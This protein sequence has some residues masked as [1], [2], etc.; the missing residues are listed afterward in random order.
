M[1]NDGAWWSYCLLTARMSFVALLTVAVAPFLDPDALAD[2]RARQVEISARLVEVSQSDI[3]ELGF[4]RDAIG[5]A[6]GRP[7]VVTRPTD[8]PPLP[9]DIVI[10]GLGSPRITALDGQQA[11]FDAVEEVPILAAGGV[12][13]VVLP[14]GLQLQIVPVIQ[15]DGSITMSIDSRVSMPS[16]EQGVPSLAT[17]TMDS[18][19]QMRSGQS[20][21]IGGLFTDSDRATAARV[22][23]LGDVPMIGQLFRSERFQ[24]GES[25]LLIFI[26]PV[27]IVGDEDAPM[28][29]ISVSVSGSGGYGEIDRGNFQLPIRV[30]TGG[31]FQDAPEFD[32][33]GT[34]FFSTRFGLNLDLGRLT[35]E[36]YLVGKDLGTY[37]SYG[38]SEF[39]GF[40]SFLAGGDVNPG[41]DGSALLDPGGLNGNLGAV[42]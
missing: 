8:T 38:F 42:A 35:G 10:R 30:E 32:T 1:R 36:R 3:A 14:V 4:D 39:D 13:P 11:V 29:G 7:A 6:M 9:D 26:S 23:A 27:L 18:S 25:D 17:R 28:R 31:Q 21:A 33:A 16:F 34:E 2:V 12:D 40:D 41:M 37:F 20:V 15:P 24:R 22:P 5:Q 19:V